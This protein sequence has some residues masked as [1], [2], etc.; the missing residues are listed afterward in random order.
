[1]LVTL[2][3]MQT[4]DASR[5]SDISPGDVLRFSKFRFLM[6]QPIREVQS[7]H[8]IMKL[9]ARVCSIFRLFDSGKFAL[10][11]LNREWVKWSLIICLKNI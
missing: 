8:I 11:L 4:S 9:Y 6:T 3:P 7:F 2:T 10:D 1:M 5:R